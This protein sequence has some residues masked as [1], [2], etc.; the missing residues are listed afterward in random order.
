[1]LGLHL[2]HVEQGAHLDGRQDGG[3]FFRRVVV[4]LA[5]YLQ[6]AVEEDGFA[7]GNKLLF[8]GRHTDVDVGAFHLGI[9]HL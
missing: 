4:A 3:I 2:L 1:M 7:R 5:I 6:E 9:S 8:V